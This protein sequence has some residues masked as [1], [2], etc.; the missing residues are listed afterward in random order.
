VDEEALPIVRELMR[1]QL[2]NVVDKTVQVSY[3]IAPSK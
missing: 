1:L 3:I 2:K